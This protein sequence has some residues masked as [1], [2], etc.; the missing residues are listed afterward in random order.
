[1]RSDNGRH[2]TRTYVSGYRS[3]RPCPYGASAIVSLQYGDP[4]LVCGY[5]A[6][7]Y[8]AGAVYPLDWS[9]ERIRAWRL[10]N[11][12]RLFHDRSPS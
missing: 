6:R 12:D 3:G 2:C 7:A 9:L 10:D 4:F 11:L 8:G 5:H 1:V